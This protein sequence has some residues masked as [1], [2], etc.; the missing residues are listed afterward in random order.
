MDWLNDQRFVVNESKPG[1]CLVTS[2]VPQG[3]ILRLVVFN[4]FSNDLNAPQLKAL[5]APKWFYGS[6]YEGYLWTIFKSSG[7]MRETQ[8]QM[9]ALFSVNEE[10]K[11]MSCEEWV[12]AVATVILVTW[13][14]ECL[15]L[16]L[17]KICTLYTRRLFNESFI[18]TRKFLWKAL[19]NWNFLMKMFHPKFLN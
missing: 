14:Q 11:S 2:S 5:G 7:R 12:F 9:T 10:S 15:F 4:V 3:S 8:S 16:V 18:K 17:T 6:A 19:M 13:R 1:W